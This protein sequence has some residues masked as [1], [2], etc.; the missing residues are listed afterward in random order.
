ML[1]S[2]YIKWELG[3]RIFAILLHNLTLILT[4]IIMVSLCSLVAKNDCFK[5]WKQVY[6]SSDKKTFMLSNF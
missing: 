6:L 1:F 4:Q 2:K 5:K 3:L